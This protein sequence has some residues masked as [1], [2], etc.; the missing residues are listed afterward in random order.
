MLHDVNDSDKEIQLKASIIA[1]TAH[2]T[3]A[4][5]QAQRDAKERDR[6]KREEAQRKIEEEQAKRRNNPA[7][8]PPSNRYHKHHK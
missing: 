5:V 2:I 7:Y 3:D 4:E 8:V 1:H 6:I